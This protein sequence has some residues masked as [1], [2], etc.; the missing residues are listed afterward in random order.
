MGRATAKCAGDTPSKLATHRARD[1]QS[2]GLF[3]FRPQN[4]PGSARPAA[5]MKSCGE[6]TGSTTRTPHR[7]PASE[8]KRHGGTAGQAAMSGA[9]RDRTD[10][11]PHRGTCR[12]GSAMTPP[13][14][15]TSHDQQLDAQASAF[16]QLVGLTPNDV[17]GAY[18]R[19]IALG[20]GLFPHQIEGVA[21]LLG[22]RRAILADD[23]GLGK[24]RQAIVALRHAVAGRAVPR[25]LP[26]IGEAQLGA[27]DRAG[28]PRQFRP[29]RRRRGAAPASRCGMDR[30]QLR[31]PV[32]ARRRV[33]ARAVGGPRVRRSA[34]P[35]EPHERAQSV[36]RGNSRNRQ[37]RM[38]HESRPSSCSPA[39]R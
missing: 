20:D 34:L 12:K 15:I 23:M 24:T 9:M 33:R 11:V 30:R 19:A 3:H 5:S 2:A 1:F 36:S 17:D 6:S 35:E 27:R 25:G 16:A 18:R 32:E 4:R 39:H 13:D 29:C 26:G 31:H 37:P 7:R 38:C 22:R 14:P 28:G 8:A 21:F 10:S